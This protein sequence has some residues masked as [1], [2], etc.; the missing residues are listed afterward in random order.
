MDWGNHVYINLDKREDRN[1]KAIRQL[2][3]IGIENPNR[4]SAIQNNDGIIGCAL[5][6]IS[7][8]EKAMKD[9]LPYICVFEDD[10]DIIEP[11]ILKDKVDRLIDAQ[12]GFDVLM[13]GGNNFGGKKIGLDLIKVEK[14]YT[15][16]SYIINEHYYQTWI[17]NLKEGLE[18]L[19]RTGDRQ[20]S[21]DAHNHKLQQKDRWYLLIPIC[22]IQK[23]GWSDIENSK[24][25]YQDLMLDYDKS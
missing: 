2:K 18:Q 23:R 17:D 24:I 5:S 16:T 6:H 13:L 4:F 11:K 25:D 3:K 20:Y 1:S 8:I 15:T 14:C 7:V 19:I 9:K 22:I 10:I 12:G 21:L